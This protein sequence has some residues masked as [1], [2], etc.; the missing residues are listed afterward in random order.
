M[1]KPV[2]VT[3]GA[4]S[5]LDSAMATEFSKMGYPLALLS[6]NL[7]A[8][9]QLNLPNV[10]CQSVDVSDPFSLK[11]AV[12]EIEEKFGWWRQRIMNLNLPIFLLYPKF[13]LA[14]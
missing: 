13:P 6:R 7:E 3:T 9:Q 4:S 10:I 2:I 11:N 14:S 8:M 12:Q 5:G 1:L